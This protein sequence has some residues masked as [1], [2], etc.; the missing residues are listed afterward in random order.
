MFV[1]G[2]VSRENP[3][4]L[5]KFLKNNVIVVCFPSHTTHVLQPFDVGIAAP[6]KR[7]LKKKYRMHL[8]SEWKSVEGENL[9]EAEKK[10]IAL[11]SAII[12]ATD[13]SFTR[14]NCIHAWRATGLHPLDKNRVLKSQKVIQSKK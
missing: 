6:F 14:T 1:D 4:T 13:I 10:R 9:N 5:E 12:D 2:H 11:V 7:E 3:Q 8:R